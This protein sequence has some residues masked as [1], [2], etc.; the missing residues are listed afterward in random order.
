MELS[1]FQSYTY[2]FVFNIVFGR[3][4]SARWD[5]WELTHADVTLEIFS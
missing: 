1:Q 4:I 5:G 3:N 2:I